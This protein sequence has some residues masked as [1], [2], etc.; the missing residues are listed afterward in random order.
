MENLHELKA[1]FMRQWPLERVEKMKIE[2]YTNLDKNS[3]F[4]YWL[5]SKTEKLG[6]IRG[7]SSFK[8]GIYE[9]GRKDKNYNTRGMLSDGNYAWYSK[10]GSNPE[11][12]FSKMKGLIIEIIKSVNERKF[13]Q[14]DNIDFGGDAIKWKIAFLYSDY[15]VLNIFNRE[16][17]WSIARHNGINLSKGISINWIQSEILKRKPA[18]EDYYIFSGKLWDLYSN[19]NPNPQYWLF[20]PGRDAIDWDNCQKNDTM[21]INWK[22]LP[23][24]TEFTDKNSLLTAI[25]ETYP[26]GATPYQSASLIWDY[27]HNVKV[28]DYIFAKIGRKKLLGYGI[29]KSN[30]YEDDSMADFNQLRDVQWIKTGTWTI[31]DITFPIRTFTKINYS[32]KLLKTM[33]NDNTHFDKAEPDILVDLLKY[34]KQIILQGAP[35]TGKT[36]QAKE[37]AAKLLKLKSIDELKDHPRFNLVQFHPSYSYEDFVKGMVATPAENGMGLRFEVQNK[38]FAKLAYDAAS[39]SKDDYV[40]IID[41]INRANLSAVLGELIYALEYRGDSLDGIYDSHEIKKV[42]VPEKLYIIG[43]MNT[44]DRS[45]GVID[46]AIRRRFAFVDILPQNLSREKDVEFA[47][48]L[49]K[50]VSELFIKDF[51]L[52]VDYNLS[53]VQLER[54]LHLSEEFD[55]K[56]VWLGHSYFI[57]KAV[58]GGDMQTRL[59]Y[60]IKPILKEYV[61]D[62][63]LKTTALDIIEKLKVEDE[64]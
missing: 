59:D 55:P 62:G 41:E 33:E 9:K 38:T 29:V 16:A 28:G 3:S 34:K 27:V 14:I 49:F 54:S 13:D 53:H 12:V 31:P 63:I 10:Y 44:A 30:Y 45:V 47:A 57:D 58:D 17:L 37:L 51:D 6:S 26:N 22:D 43:T 25:A 5:E 4:C 15:E 23:P 46:Y 18:D 7:G 20:V 64:N 35:G 50:T 52:E 56:D 24:L 2:E 39:N 42:I 1:E 48:D 21:A 61:R 32:D 60:E 40:I 8:F 36:K 11:E 19:D